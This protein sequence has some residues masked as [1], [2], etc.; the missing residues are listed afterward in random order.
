[1]YRFFCLLGSL[2]FGTALVAQ[3]MGTLVFDTIQFDGLQRSFI[4]FE[5][6]IYTGTEAVPLVLNLHGSGSNAI[7]QIVYSQF[8]FVADTAGFLV[9]IP[10]AVDNEWNA[11]FSGTPTSA[12]DDVG[13]LTALMDTI[14]AN[15]MIDP[16]RVYSTGMSLGG[17]M[18]YRLACEVPERLA[19]IASVTGTMA[20]GLFASCN[21]AEAVPVMQIHGTADST[22]L[23]LGSSFSTAI[24]TVMDFWIA[25]NEC[26]GGPIIEDFPDITADNTTVQSR[27][28]IACRD[29]SEVLLYVIEKGGHTWAGSFPI[30]GAGNTNQDIRAHAE[31]WKFFLRHQR[32]DQWT[33]L[34]SPEAPVVRL[35]PNPGGDFLHVEGPAGERAILLD[36]TGRQHRSGLLTPQGIRWE[37]PGLAEGIYWVKVGGAPAQTWLLQR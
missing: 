21:P 2:L 33:G 8:N 12:P 20:N 11:G 35:Y 31:I 5:P 7:E 9:V 15:Y 19:A 36:A 23:Y 16:D 28:W 29:W 30:P 32:G 26:P 3:P 10:D 17:F 24:E 1:M 34:T 4:V 22:V 13:F 6:D 18:S 27:R 14:A 37:L 25:N